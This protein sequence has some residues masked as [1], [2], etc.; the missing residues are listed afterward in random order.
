MH[1]Q[2]LTPES[3]SSSIDACEWR[4]DKDNCRKIAALNPKRPTSSSDACEQPSAKCLLQ[5]CPLYRLCRLVNR[6]NSQPILMLQGY[7]ADVAVLPP[8]TAEDAPIWRA[9]HRFGCQRVV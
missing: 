3:M 1:L 4:T 7:A 5:S 9:P 6:A 2:S 8:N